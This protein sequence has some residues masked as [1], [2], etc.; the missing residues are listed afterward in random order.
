MI[1]DLSIMMLD[2]V[3]EISIIQDRDGGWEV[4]CAEALH[5]ILLHPP[6]P[7]LLRHPRP[8]HILPQCLHHLC[9][10]NYNDVTDRCKSM[11]TKANPPQVRNTH[12]EPVSHHQ[13]LTLAACFIMYVG[14]GWCHKD[15]DKDKDKD[16]FI[17]YIG[18]R[19]CHQTTRIRHSS[20]SV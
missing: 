13:W 19:L 4:L 20:S 7:P 2:I 5:Q 15:K 16:C 11:Q 14:Q 6:L 1:E 17:M 12:H 18:Q 9:G 3:V 10:N 8:H